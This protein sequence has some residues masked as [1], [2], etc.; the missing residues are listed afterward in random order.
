MAN[1]EKYVVCEGY[2][3]NNYSLVEYFI[4]IYP[5]IIDKDYS[6]IS[7]LNLSLP[8]YFINKIEDYNGQDNIKELI[9]INV[10]KCV[11]WCTRHN[12]SISNNF[13]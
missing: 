9:S 11:N 5:R 2:K 8:Y 13:V 1:S 6:L 3:N 7:I 10:T 4:K 12:I